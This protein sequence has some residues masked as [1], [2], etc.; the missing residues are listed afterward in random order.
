MKVVLIKIPYYFICKVYIS[1]IFVYI[2]LGLLKVIEILFSIAAAISAG[3]VYLCDPCG[4]VT[5]LQLVSVLAVV[6]T[7]VMYVVF[8]L[9]LLSKSDIINWPL[10]DLINC[11][12]FFILYI[13]S[14][15]VLAASSS[16]AAERSA[17][18]FGFMCAI[19]FAASAWFAYKVFIITYRKHNS[20]ISHIKG[21][22]DKTETEVLS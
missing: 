5:F 17:V 3:C 14:S 19:L 20:A 11:I 1:L 16:Q 10:T 8:A 18:A 22:A 21:V 15:S 9:N 13:I 6:M 4:P 12:A 7:F 2:F